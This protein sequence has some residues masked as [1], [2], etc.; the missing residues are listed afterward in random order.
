MYNVI[1]LWELQFFKHNLNP[2]QLMLSL[3]YDLITSLL[4]T[5]QII[6]QEKL[7]DCSWF[8]NK[9]L[10]LYLWPTGIISSEQEHAKCLHFKIFTYS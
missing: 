9:H 4:S 8:L 3:L 10:S 1:S 5:I 2:T 7:N 6:I